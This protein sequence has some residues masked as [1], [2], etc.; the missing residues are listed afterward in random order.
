VS[1]Y[2]EAI[3]EIADSCSVCCCVRDDNDLVATVNESL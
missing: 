3:C 1:G 2:F